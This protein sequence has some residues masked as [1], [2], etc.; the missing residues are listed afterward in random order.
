[1]LAFF[2]PMN[3][4]LYTLIDITLILSTLLTYSLKSFSMSFKFPDYHSLHILLSLNTVKYVL[5]KKLSSFN[6]SDTAPVGSLPSP[7]NSLI[8]TY[9]SFL[10]LSLCPSIHFFIYLIHW[11]LSPFITYVYSP[12]FSFEVHCFLPNLFLK[13]MFSNKVLRYSGYHW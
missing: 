11:L 8:S 9:F 6:Y 10:C 7:L 1:M 3:T 4:I 5:F 13:Q 12:R 2:Y